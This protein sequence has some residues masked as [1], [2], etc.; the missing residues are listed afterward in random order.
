MLNLVCLIIGRTFI[1][2]TKTMLLFTGLTLLSWLVAVCRSVNDVLS[3]HGRS[4][5]RE[6]LW[7]TGSGSKRDNSPIR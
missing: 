7:R 3:K 2:T 6:N 4:Y 1:P 5:T